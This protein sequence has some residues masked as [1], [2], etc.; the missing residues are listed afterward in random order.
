MAMI[1]TIFQNLCDATLPFR[2]WSLANPLV[3]VSL[4]VRVVCLM[5]A[6]CF[7]TL[8]PTLPKSVSDPQRLE[9][10]RVASNLTQSSITSPVDR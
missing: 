1:A 5:A 6:A 2:P 7:S 9:S 10:T 8:T 3:P 4:V